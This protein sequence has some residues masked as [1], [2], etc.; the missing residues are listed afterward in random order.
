MAADGTHAA[1]ATPGAIEA[2]RWPAW[3]RSDVPFLLVLFAAGLLLLYLGRSLTFFQDEW[4][5]VSRFSDGVD[6]ADVIRPWNEHWT[7]LP[8][9]LYAATFQAIGLHSYLPYLV[10]LIALHL[11]VVLGVY[12]LARRRT[13]RLAAALLSL[14]LLLVGSGS[15]NLFWAFQMAF[16]GSA[17]FGTWALVFVEQRGRRSAV[18]ASLALTAG[19]MCSG[20]GLVFLVAM[21][22]RTVLDSHRRRR[23]GVLVLPVVTYLTWFA[24]VG[25][26]GLAGR[27]ELAQI[28]DIASF[29]VR[30]I[31]HAVGSFSGL[32][33]VPGGGVIGVLL[34]LAALA[35]A[36]WLIVIRREPVALAFGSLAAIVAMYVLIGSVRA[37]AAS[38]LATRGRYVYVAAVFITIAVSDLAARIRLPDRAVRWRTLAIVGAGLVVALALV[39]NLTALAAERNV[40]QREAD[41]T[42]AY[43]SLAIDR[44]DEPWVDPATVLRGMP[45][46]P[47]LVA[48]IDRS[49]SPLRDRIVPSVAR[50]PRASAREWALIRMV[51]DG[52]RTEAASRG[53]TPIGLP[54]EVSDAVAEPDGQCLRVSEAG[55]RAV[56]RLTPPAGTRISVASAEPVDGRAVIGR[57]RTPSRFIPLRVGASAP[58]DVVVPD[59]GD[60]GTW[61]VWLRIGGAQAPIDVCGRQ[62]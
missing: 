54:F 46:L 17:M 22:G 25:R 40:M 33:L 10:E 59:T 42:R 44:G 30:G 61:R 34:L 41:R 20:I 19:L 6:V 28:V 35:G 9:L 56:L 13:G 36:G 32:S 18:L 51:G 2:D 21:A 49:G 58:R 62:P 14:P 52:F 23:A 7:T 31:G 12:A 26:E 48:L 47:E 55:P 43:V 8:A 39:V 3:S 37:E 11:L 16:V 4:G 24:L 5:F 60:G 50:Q 45:P 53:G 1:S 38:D 27:R 57:D 15:E 29:A